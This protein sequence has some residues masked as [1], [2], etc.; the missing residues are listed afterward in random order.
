MKSS[1][2][3]SLLLLMLS[4]GA[5]EQEE[6]IT[7]EEASAAAD[8]VNQARQII[9]AAIAA[10]YGAPLTEADIRFD[11]RDRAYGISTADGVYRYTRTFPDTTETG[12]R[13]IEDEL[14]NEGF[15]RRIDGEITELE[16]ERAQAYGN[17]VNSVRY[18]FLLPYG[19]NDPATNAEYIGEVSIEGEP[20]HKIKVTFDQEGGGVDYEDV[21]YY[22][23]HQDTKELDYL[24][25]SFHVEGGGLRFRKA[26]DQRRVNG[27]L[28]QD[29]I[30]YGGELEQDFDRIE[31]L[32]EQ[33]E[34]EELSRIVNENIE[35]GGEE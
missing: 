17:S 35:V 32:Y 4:C 18:F 16:A 3:F 21:Y 28:F 14:T 9:N 19:L 1:I 10:H 5:G 13:L 31:E 27:L 26:I 33:G 15:I 22:Y 30:N 2:I 20:Y 12:I 7:E 29:Y 25:Y 23:F 6:M 8:T 34:L 11:F 24:A